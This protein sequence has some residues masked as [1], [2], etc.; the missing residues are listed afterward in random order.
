[1]AGKHIVEVSDSSFDK[2]V[3]EKSKKVPVVVDFWAEWCGPCRF[4]GPVLEK[5]SSEY[6]GKFILAKLDVDGN[7]E[8]A[9]EYDISSIPSVKMFKDGEVIAEFLGAIPESQVRKWLES[10]L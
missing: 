1:M 10:N 5:L 6:E 4:L 7:T 9:Q 2:E 3:I 8:K